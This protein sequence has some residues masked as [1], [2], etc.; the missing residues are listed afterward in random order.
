MPGGKTKFTVEVNVI[1]FIH[2]NVIDYDGEVLAP[3]IHEK[4]NPPPGAAFEPE[5]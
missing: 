3:A 5:K 1:L 4:G 2:D